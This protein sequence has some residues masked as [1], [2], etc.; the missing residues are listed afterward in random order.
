MLG[1][2]NRWPVAAVVGVAAVWLL[3]VP[4]LYLSLRQWWALR[5]ANALP[6]TPGSMQMT[7]LIV[8]ISPSPL[9]QWLATVLLVVPPLMMVIHWWRGRHMSGST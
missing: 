5:H 3:V 6:Q 4:T 9:E 8:E 1:R 7:Y 2:L